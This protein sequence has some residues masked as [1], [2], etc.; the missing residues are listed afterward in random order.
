MLIF[1]FIFFVA[2]LYRDGI[3]FTPFVKSFLPN[4]FAKGLLETV[5]ITSAKPFPLCLLP[6]RHAAPLTTAAGFARALL[7]C[8]LLLPAGLRS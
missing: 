4:C 5:F 1:Y 6:L 8:S 3:A 2:F 7:F